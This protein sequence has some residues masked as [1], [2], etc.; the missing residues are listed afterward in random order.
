MRAEPLRFAS[1]GGRRRRTEGAEAGRWRGTKTNP[2][3]PRRSGG[4]SMWTDGV[5]A[6]TT[7]RI[8]PFMGRCRPSVRRLA[9]TRTWST[10]V[11]PS[12]QVVARVRVRVATT[13]VSFVCCHRVF[14]WRLRCK[15]LCGDVAHCGSSKMGPFIKKEKIIA[16]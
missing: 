7:K 12:G 16:S 2:R 6:R 10:R 8:G 15:F 9:S 5:E 11:G 4:V 14:G 13:S 1:G 3:R